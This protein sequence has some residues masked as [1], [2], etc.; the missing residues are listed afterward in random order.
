MYSSEITNTRS[1]MSKCG[2]FLVHIFPYLDWIRS[3][4]VLSPN[5]GK[6]GP[7]KVRIW[8]IFTQCKVPANGVNLDDI[9]VKLKLSTLKFLHPLWTLDLYH[10]LTS[11]EGRKVVE[12]GWK[13]AGI[14]DAMSKGVSGLEPFCSIGSWI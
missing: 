13:S 7:E 12:N 8:T 11:N 14:T 3:E 4:Y 10:Y 5:A 6:Y 2:V 1:K 9:K